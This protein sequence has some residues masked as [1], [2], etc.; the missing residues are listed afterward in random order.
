MTAKK[1]VVRETLLVVAEGDAEVAFV[2]YLKSLYL[3]SLGRSVQTTNAHGKGGRH[4]L[5]VAGRRANNR[6]HDKVVLLLDTDTDW[7]DD[8]REKARRSRMGRRGRLD[9]IVSRPC[10]E[11]WLLEILGIRPPPNTKQCKKLF[12]DRMACEAHEPGWMKKH[13]SREVLD[14]ARGA[15]K[16]LAELM[17]HMGIPKP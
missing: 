5:D 11:A 2:R 3:D 16:P 14:G 12:K 10:L 17:K 13:L 4:V 7:T 1:R 9:V 6:D 8:E 15:V